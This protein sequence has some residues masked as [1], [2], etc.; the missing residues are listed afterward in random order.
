[1]KA[2]KIKAGT[3]FNKTRWIPV[4]LIFVQVVLGILTVTLSPF[5]NNLVYF[6]VTHQWVAM[7]FLMSLL[8]M[9]YLMTPNP[10]ES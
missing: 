9:W 10:K 5:G 6:G 1:V 8:L 2:S 3:F 7:M 4:V